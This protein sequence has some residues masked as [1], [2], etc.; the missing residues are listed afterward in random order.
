MLHPSQSVSDSAQTVLDVLQEK[1]PNPS[2]SGTDAFMTCDTLP[3]LIG[4]DI[5]GG[6][7]GTCG[8]GG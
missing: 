1:H 5:T 8:E 3:P 6:G 7:G 4:A 2:L